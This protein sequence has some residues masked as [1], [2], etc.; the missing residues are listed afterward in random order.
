M[1]QIYDS[2]G[3]LHWPADVP[4]QPVERDALVFAVLSRKLKTTGKKNT[5]T[6]LRLTLRNMVQT[7]GIFRLM[8]AQQNTYRALRGN[9]T[10]C[11]ISAKNLKSS[12]LHMK[13]KESSTVHRL[14][15][16]SYQKYQAIR[17]RL[18][19]FICRITIRLLS[20]EFGK[21]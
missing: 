7:N 5:G 3:R 19:Q 16:I 14:T 1:Y 15:K 12:M 18:V 9:G 2:P 20:V 21:W 10:C 8:G 13:Y 6:L 17:K 4:T 11:I